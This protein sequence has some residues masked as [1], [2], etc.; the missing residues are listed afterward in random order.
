MICPGTDQQIEATAFQFDFGVT[1]CIAERTIDLMENQIRNTVAVAVQDNE[2]I[3]PNDRVF[4]R[5]GLQVAAEGSATHAPLVPVA[6]DPRKPRRPG[7][8]AGGD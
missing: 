2:A 4:D 6:F 5:S 7:V 8:I 3:D 1:D